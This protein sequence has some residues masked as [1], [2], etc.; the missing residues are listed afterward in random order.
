MI[1]EAPA[2]LGPARCREIAEAYPFG[3]LIGALQAMTDAGEMEIEDP[4]LTGWMIGS[5]MCEAALL[6]DGAADAK[7]LKRK[8]LAVVERTL[9]A[10][11]T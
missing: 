2:A 8:A 10:F 1:Q 3:L 6:L 9:T 4:R 11:R 5:M 7:A